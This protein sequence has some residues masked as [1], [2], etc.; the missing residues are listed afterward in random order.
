V[1]GAF[2]KL[3]FPYP[4][5]LPPAPPRSLARFLW[6]CTAGLRRY[7]AA[8]TLLTAIIGMFE[9][10]LFSMLGRIVDWLGRTQPSRLWTD[11]RGSL[12]LL[13][14]VLVA[15]MVVVTLQSLLKQQ[16]LAG[17]FPM[18][19]RWNFHRLMLGQSMSFYQDE[20]AGRVAAKVMQS[21]LAVRDTWMILAELMVFVIIYFVTLMA[22]VG[23]FDAWLLVPFL[24]WVAL[25]T[26]GALLLRAAARQG[27][28]GP[29]RR[30]FADDRAHHRRLHQHRNGQ[31]LLARAPRGQLRAQCDGRVPRHGCTGRCA[32]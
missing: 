14:G 31:A 8:M 22:V 15:S 6:A 18:R 25:Y 10:F 12:L 17:N 28:Q 9:A 7:I 5:A 1:F 24:G 2:E 29:G 13:A 27:R 16:T 11:E 20:F 30:T 19:L 3:L 4:D 26:V 23:G 21:A 32:W